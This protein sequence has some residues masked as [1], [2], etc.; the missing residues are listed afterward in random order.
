MTKEPSDRDGSSVPAAG[1]GLLRQVAHD[2][3]QPVAAILALASA[4]ESEPDVPMP[5]LRR[6]DQI[7]EEASW[8]FR[9]IGDLLAEADGAQPAEPVAVNALLREVVDSER[10]TFSGQIELHLQAGEPRHVLAVGTRLRRALANVLANAT[11]AAGPDGQVELVARASGGTV[12]I[13]VADD[14]PGFGQVGQVHGI[15]LQITRQIL[16]EHGGR[17][18]TEQPSAGRTVVRL[19]LPSLSC[20]RGAGGR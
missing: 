13:E 1:Q 9:V 15:G 6:L 3:R 2:L 8:I 14:G 20:G 18:E 19:T 10:L 4:A 5:V 11:R 16:A 7:S 12:V 17:M